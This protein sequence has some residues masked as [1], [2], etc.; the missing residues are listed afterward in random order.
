LVD[1]IGLILAVVVHSADIRDRA[2]A[3]L[4]LKEIGDKYPRLKLIWADAGYSGKPLQDFVLEEHQLKLEI[5]LKPSRR[6]IVLEGVEP[7]PYPGFTVLK[8]R[9][10]VERTFAWLGRWRRMS[11]D[12]EVLESTA[13]AL[14]YSIMLRIMTARLVRGGKP[15]REA[16]KKPI[17]VTNLVN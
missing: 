2:G 10:I 1:T 4:V 17:T 5:V 13:V 7:P 8:W 12:Y 3:K 14:I 15:I 16:R 9:W 11:K 6:V